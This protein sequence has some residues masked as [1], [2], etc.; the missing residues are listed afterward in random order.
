KSAVILAGLFA[1]GETRIANASATR[2]HTERLLSYMGA[3]IKVAHDEVKVSPCTDELRP[4]EL[5]VP[6][7][8]SSAA[9]MMVAATL[10]ARGTIVLKDVGVNE[11]RTGIID[12]LRTMGA[13]ISL[14]NEHVVA[15]EEVADIHIEKSELKGA[16]FGGEHIVRM[17]DEIP[18]LALA[19][20]QA[21]GTTVIKDAT[22]L[23]VKE[24]NRILKTVECLRRMVADLDETNDGMIIRGPTKLIGTNMASF[25]DHRLALLLAIAGLIAQ[26]ST[27]IAHAEVM[28]DSY[29]GFLQSL[30]DLGAP[31]A[32]VIE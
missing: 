16:E 19:A 17:I 32:L 8:I 15:N 4:L 12:A 23:K 11:T 1:N 24:T 2:D 20:T 14:K 9:F 7:D 31:M 18:I 22:E 25:G 6:G 10:L 28:D 21:Q 27:T 29:P 13:S 5:R 30:A 3:Q 26:G